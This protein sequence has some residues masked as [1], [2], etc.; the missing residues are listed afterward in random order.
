MDKW[1]VFKLQLGL[2]FILFVINA[3]FAQNNS[4]QGRIFNSTNNEAI[5]FANIIIDGSNIGASSDLDGNFQFINVNPGYVKLIATSVGY[6]KFYSTEFLVVNGKTKY[7]DIPMH[8]TTMK[9][10]E[11]EIKA[12]TF[13]RDEESPLSMR[14]IGI[15]EIEK[16]PG[17]NRDI[18]RVIQSLPGVS[19]TPNS[20]ND[21]IV[22][23][24]GASE[25]RFYLDG[26]EI[27]TLNHFAT[28]GA[29]GGSIGIVNVDFLRE[30]ELYSGAFPA[31]KGNALSSILDMRMI[32][33]NPNSIKIKGAFG[34]S[35]LALT[36]DGPINKKTTFIFSARRSY[37]QFLFSAIGLPFLPTY[38]DFQWKS[39]IR[40]DTK[41][42]LTIIGI[43]AI[44]DSKLNT[45]IKNPNESQK[46]ILGYLPEY[47]QWNYT[48]GVN[49]KHFRKNS[50]DS[51]ILSRNMLRNISYKYPGND[52]SKAKLYDYSSD[53]IENKFRFERNIQKQDLKI[54]FGVG[55][56]YD[57]YKN[58]TKQKILA[59][60]SIINTNYNT[61]IDLYAWEVFGQV[62]DAF[63][64]NRLVLSFGIRMDANN[65]DKNMTN[66][67]DQYSPRI[68]ASYSINERLHINSNIGRFVQR[69]AYT[70]MGFRN[71]NDVLINKEN[72]ITYI[73]VN[74]AVLG[75]DY[76]V[77]SK[78]RL[79]VEGFLKWYHNY[80]FSVNDSVSLASKGTDFS[81]FG[82]EEVTSTA[83]G[84]AYGMEVYFRSTDIKGFNIILSYTFVRSE[85]K[86][87]RGQYIPSA[88][89][90]RHLFNITLKKDL[91]RNWEIG[92]K[93]RF[94][95]GAPY[96][97]ID[98]F[99][100]SIRQVWDSKGKGSLNYNAYNSERVKNYNQ[101]D[102]RI[103]KQ[104]F[105]KK[106]ALNF[107]MDVQNV[108]A[109]NADQPPIYTNLDVNGIPAVNPNDNTKYIL[110]EIDN[111]SANILPTIGV[112][113][114]F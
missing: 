100:S 69:P 34:A 110:R 75:I 6:E 41:N 101:L 106:W 88:W 30:I 54:N 63:L 36:L 39:K 107:Y 77:N 97:P 8:E 87:K 92:A 24:G 52:E 20:R 95:G 56:E 47:E 104:Y 76:D 18:S 1:G 14:S 10:A 29:S 80:P 51:Y 112:I 58:T 94:T 7:I 4:I 103:D 40:F 86:E 50:Y 3:T 26:I 43:G 32:D 67:L 72:D 31:N 45:G 27:P 46:F 64:N 16:S 102:I 38:N 78:S 53:E 109:K 82:D 60:D 42:E 81:A 33:G 2:I 61:F 66:L 19:P 9:L 28:Q 12:A 57:K 114:E 65:Y 70:T 111:S 55:L 96:T 23:G 68:S 25:N 90:N 17:S 15:A 21:I 79:S 91:G 99:T 113:V 98:L 74:H 22:R 105:F 93:W 35:D 49:Y 73:N 44:D 108:Y 71:N 89:D 5:P 84:R 37:L 48:V 11:I 59:K 83:E 85:F 13:R 62:T